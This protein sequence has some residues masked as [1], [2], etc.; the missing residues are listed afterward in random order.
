MK[1]NKLEQKL[2]E[3]GFA[4]K[5]LINVNYDGMKGFKY[6]VFE[7]VGTRVT[8]KKDNRQIDFHINEVKLFPISYNEKEYKQI[9][10]IKAGKY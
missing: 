1:N 9:Q 7:I 8:I 2:I 10:L 5:A 4:F 3:L 6:D